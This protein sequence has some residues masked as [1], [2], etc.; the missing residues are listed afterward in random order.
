[1]WTDWRTDAVTAVVP[2]SFSAAQVGT[3]STETV[4]P[5][6]VLFG[7]FLHGRRDLNSGA[8]RPAAQGEARA[9]GK[10]VQS[11]WRATR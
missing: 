2:E 9:V 3:R 1:M 4:K 8:G 7:A 6:S 11:S 10:A 5:G